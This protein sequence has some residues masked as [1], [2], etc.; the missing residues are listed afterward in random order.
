[1]HI[2]HLAA[3]SFILLGVTHMGDSAKQARAHKVLPTSSNSTTDG[4]GCLGISKNKYHQDDGVKQARA[5][6]VSPT[7][8]NT[9][10]EKVS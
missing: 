5:Q 10:M 2:M 3:L 6:K 9:T 1:M 4:K 8:S 7:P